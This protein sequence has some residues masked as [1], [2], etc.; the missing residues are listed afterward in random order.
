MILPDLNEAM[1][2]GDGIAILFFGSRAFGVDL[3][4]EHAEI[5]ADRLARQIDCASN[6]TRLTATP[7]L[8]PEARQAI[9]HYRILLRQL[10]R[11]LG[12]DRSYLIH[13]RRPLW[14]ETDS[15]EE[16]V[17][18]PQSVTSSHAS[19]TRG[20][21]MTQAGARRG[22]GNAP[23][24]GACHQK[25]L[26]DTHQDSSVSPPHRRRD[27]GTDGVTPNNPGGRKSKG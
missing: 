24:R 12:R 19:S 4:L 7:I 20:R 26:E 3:A 8:I 16:L 27:S 9:T 1:I 22:R 13:T 15:E 6:L 11:G 2:A 5:Y 23:S 25:D 21:V 18:G 17:G 14:P 10:E